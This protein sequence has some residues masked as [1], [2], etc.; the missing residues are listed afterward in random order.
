MNHSLRTLAVVGCS[1]TQVISAYGQLGEAVDAPSLGWVSGSN[2]NTSNSE[3]FA[4]GSETWDG[5]DAARSG[6]IE[7]NKSTWIQTEITG[8]G[9]ISFR[10]K[11]SSNQ[12]DHYLSLFLGKPTSVGE[13]EWLSRGAISGEVDWAPMTVTVPKGRHLVR[14]QYSKNNQVAVGTDAGWVDQVSFHSVAEVA[15]GDALE[16]ETLSWSSGGS[17]GNGDVEWF[18]QSIEH[19]DGADAARTPI[20]GT[21]QESWIETEVDGPGTVSFRWK[22]S[23]NQSDHYLSMLTGKPLPHGVEWLSRGAISGSVDWET[24]TVVVPKG[25]HYL[26]WRYSKNNQIDIGHDAG[27]LDTVTFTATE[28][29]SLSDAL[30]GNQLSWSSS[31]TLGK[32]MIAWSGQTIEHADGTDAART[33][34]IGTNEFTWV[35]TEVVGP[36]TVSFL[37]K[38]SSNQS[39]HYLR[40][41]LGKPTSGFEVEWLTRGSISG[42]VGWQPRSITVPKGRH[43]VRW[44]YSKN[45]QVDIGDDAGWL[46]QVLFNPSS[47]KTLADALDSDQLQWLSGGSE[48]KGHVEWYGQMEESSDGIDAA[49]TPIIGASEVS[50]LETSVIGP[51]VITF[52]WKVSSN[53]SDHYLVYEVGDAEGPPDWGTVASISG[54]VNWNTR[55][56]DVP[57][58]VKRLRWRYSKNNQVDIGQDAGWIDNVYFTPGSFNSSAKLAVGSVRYDLATVEG[59]ADRLIIPLRNLG[60]QP[61][62]IY[63]ASFD[64]DW[65]AIVNPTQPIGSLSTM[66]LIVDIST[67]GIG[68]GNYEGTLRIESSATNT[69]TQDI[70]VGVSVLSSVGLPFD[71]DADG[72]SDVYEEIHG[73]N[74]LRDDGNE[75]FDQDGVSNYLESVY[76]TSA[77]DQ[78]SVPILEVSFARATEVI[79]PTEVGVIYQIQSTTDLSLGIWSDVGDPISGTGDVVSR[80]FSQLGKDRFFYRV[81]MN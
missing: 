78:G 22:V 63:E 25:R 66:G 39:D 46:D 44:Q 3:W 64:Q 17:L 20:I 45:N 67:A 62:S 7:S 18:G 56:F 16:A 23:S 53:Q 68:P 79:I 43:F 36:G 47:E 4:Q 50:W 74:L 65:G 49:R 30:D 11:V 37:W 12:S 33:P 26:R 19:S 70:Q 10:W 6:Q 80:F 8:P 29:V 81:D 38:V 61:L 73:L 34:I 48:G 72:M 77:S 28:D 52:N 2:A 54:E 9:T 41:H 59:G 71:R 69:P 57:A 1:L 32:G 13:F 40:V 27:W 42:E 35:E 55:S 21:N 51:G 75:D 14:W 58:G 60:V 5:V 15:L 24:R 31:G 76:G